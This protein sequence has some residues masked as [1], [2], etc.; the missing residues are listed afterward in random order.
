MPNR[1]SWSCMDCSTAV[2][3]GTKRCKSCD[4]A[5]RRSNPQRITGGRGRRW[6]DDD[7][8]KLREARANGLTRAETAKLLNRSEVSVIAAMH[9]YCPLPSD[10]KP[11]P[12]GL[13]P[14]ERVIYDTL[15]EAAKAGKRCPTQRSLGLLIDRSGE[16]ARQ[17][18][19]RLVSMGKIELRSGRS[20]RSVRI[21]ATGHKTAFF[22]QL[23]TALPK[24]A[25]PV[26]NVVVKLPP[27]IFRDPCPGCGVRL[28]ADPALCCARGRALRRLVA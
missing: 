17:I 23:Q 9:V 4:L 27:R 2:Y 12:E 22:D 16:A 26:V 7:I 14:M 1:K 5:E 3:E 28:D 13:Y 20:Y 25:E 18:I 6:H 21:A 8:A 15:A 24:V 19:V 11:D 10:Q